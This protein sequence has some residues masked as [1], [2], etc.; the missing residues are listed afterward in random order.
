M[1]T[2]NRSASE[3]TS[4]SGESDR[5]STSEHLNAWLGR[6]AEAS[7]A[8]GGGAACAVMLGIS[9][10]LLR[11]VAEYTPDDARAAEAANRLDGHRRAALDAAE[12]DGVRSAELGAALG[13]PAKEP[14]RDDRVRDAAISAA[15]S[16]AELGAIGVSL[17]N[18]LR[19]LAT[20]GNSHLAADLAVA[21][22]A[23]AAGIAGALVNLR[24]NLQ[25]TRAHLVG[26]D[27]V[28]ER[29]SQLDHAV[30]ELR[31]AHRAASAIADEQ[32]AQFDDR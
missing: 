19:L 28:A 30:R 4:T 31:T 11:M 24:A 20:I 32:S 16:S 29:L 2:S 3:G 25:F 18:E 7:G 8:P 10:A 21:G 6:L 9:A 5:V 1:V 15:V 13:L 14:G 22:E 27:G 12:A 23:L 17:L 26:D